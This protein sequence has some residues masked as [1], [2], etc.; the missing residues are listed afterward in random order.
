MIGTAVLL[1]TMPL[2]VGWLLNWYMNLHPETFPPMFIIGLAF[3]LAWGFASW[4]LNRKMLA[5]GAVL[6][7]QHAVAA[8]MLVLVAIQLLMLPFVVGVTYEFN[9]YV[10]G[11]DNPFTNFLAKPGL[12]MQNFT[13]FEPDD[14]MIEVAITAMKLV[15]P[16]ERGKDAW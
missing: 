2:A 5:T 14:G 1:G 8:I 15:I 6:L 16:E 10:G 12:W 11:H 3:L 9:R 7:A 13:T 4:K